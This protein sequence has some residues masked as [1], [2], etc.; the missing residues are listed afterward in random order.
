VLILEDLSAEVPDTNAFHWDLKK[1]SN[2]DGKNAL[3]YGYNASNNK[4]LIEQTTNYNRIYFNNWAPC[5]FAQW[6]THGVSSLQY[7]SPFNTVYTICPYTANWINGLAYGRVYKN[8]F[9]PFCPSLI[10]EVQEKKYDVIYH[11]GIHGKEHTQCLKVMKKHNYRYCTMTRYINGLTQFHLP[12]ATNTNLKF[13]EKINLVAQTKISVCYNLVHIKPEHSKAIKHHY[14]YTENEAFS[15]LGSW[16][17]MPQFKTRMHE[18][19]ISRTLNLVQKD[20]WNI[21]EM[22]YEPET[23][24][25][26]FTD[27]K[28]LDKKIKDISSDWENYSEIVDRAYEKSLSY[29]TDKFISKIKGELN[30]M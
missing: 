28:D 4:Q 25:I 15:M 12:Y 23:E 19:A 27:D 2:D 11:G 21:A 26:Y 24:F 10:P 6:K 17:V 9:Y 5:E 1:F 8:I 14:K 16:E 7:E 30:E 13:K 29:T 22:Y 18:A 20:E 3:F